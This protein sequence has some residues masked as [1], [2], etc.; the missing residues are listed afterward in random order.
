MFSGGYKSDQWLQE[1]DNSVLA[2]IIINLQIT[3]HIKMIFF[4]L[5]ENSLCM[6]SKKMF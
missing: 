3:T 6:A 4:T 5:A 1:F 2:R